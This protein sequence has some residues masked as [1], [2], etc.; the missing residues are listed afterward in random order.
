M[1]QLATAVK[2]FANGHRALSVRTNG[3]I[4]PA[5]I[6]ASLKLPPCSRLLLI[7]GGAGNMSEE[8]MAHLSDLFAVVGQVVAKYNATVIDGGTQSGVMKLMGEALAKTGKNITHIGVLPAYAEAGP[9]L[10]AEDILEPHHSNFVLVEGYLW[11]DEVETMYELAGYFSARVPSVTLLINGGAIALHEVE[12]N[13]R[14]GRE[15][16]VLAGS[17][18]LA[19][20]IAEAAR[21]PAGNARDRIAAIVRKGRITVFDI[22][23]PPQELGRLLEQRLN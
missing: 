9:K 4:D 11:G 21:R 12:W 17:G 19:D 2:N 8:M 3:Q 13:V 14:Q 10:Q 7:S 22:A 20:E 5:V 23:S 15:V 18:R 1:S 6:V 16:I